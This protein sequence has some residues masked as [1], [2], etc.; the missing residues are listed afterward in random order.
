MD[1]KKQILTATTMT[2]GD[3]EVKEKLLPTLPLIETKRINTVGHMVDAI[4]L[5]LSVIQRHQ[6]TKTAQRLTT[7]KVDPMHTAPLHE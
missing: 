4:T 5:L 6:A 1:N 7:D 3:T 2:V